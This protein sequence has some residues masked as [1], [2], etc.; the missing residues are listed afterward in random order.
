VIFGDQPSGSNAQREESA[1][2]EERARDSTGN[3]DTARAHGKP[4]VDESGDH[5]R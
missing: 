2:G 4:P 5:K 3:R 1:P